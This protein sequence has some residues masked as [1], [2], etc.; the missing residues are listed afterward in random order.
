MPSV[1][2]AEAWKQGPAGG[3]GLYFF[4]GFFL[5]SKPKSEPATRASTQDAPVP[6]SR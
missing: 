5:E 4:A 3:G 2:Q 6:R 1:A